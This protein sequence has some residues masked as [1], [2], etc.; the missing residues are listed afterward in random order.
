VVATVH[1]I[2]LI[3]HHTQGTFSGYTTGGLRA[4]WLATV[5]HTPLNPNARITGGTF[6]LATSLNQLD[7]PLSAEI[8]R[9][10]ITNTNPG[11]NCSN[12]TFKVTGSLAPF[13]HYRTGTFSL[14]LTHWR[15]NLLGI[16]LSYFA[17]TQ[18]PSR[19]RDSSLP[20]ASTVGC[21]GCPSFCVGGSLG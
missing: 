9:G 11:A 14:T 6:T 12:Q 1:G 20:L 15:H 13:N 10:T 3:A 16:C 5:K 19:S 4:G 21:R 17:T 8:S 7:H 18:G 2:E